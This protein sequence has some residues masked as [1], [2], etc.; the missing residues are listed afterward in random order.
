MRSLRFVL[1][2][3]G[4]G[5]RS[6]FLLSA[7]LVV[8]WG[9]VRGRYAAADPLTS[10]LSDLGLAAD[11]TL[12][13]STPRRTLRTFLDE[14]RAGRFDTAA[15]C[16]DLRG[17]PDARGGPELAEELSYILYRRPSLDLTRVPDDPTASSG[18]VTVDTFSAGDRDVPLSLSRVRFKDGVFRW[19]ISESTVTRIPEL[20][21]ALRSAVWR[22]VLPAVLQSPVILGNAPWQWLGVLVSL[23]VAYAVGRLFARMGR[24]IGLRLVKRSATPVDELMVK[25]SERPLRTI[26]A[27]LLFGLLVRSLD[28]SLELSKVL[29]HVGYSGFVIGL[30][31]LLLA[32]FGIVAQLASPDA[33]LVDR[34]DNPGRRT[35]RALLQR[36]ASAGVVGVTAAL[37]LLQFDVV[38]HVGLSLLASAGI[39]S[40]VL[41]FAGQKSISG[42]IAGIQLSITQ[43]VR[44]GDTIFIEGESGVVEDIFLTYAVIR[45]ID[46]RCLIVPLTRFLDQPFQNWTL[47]NRE[48]S[49]IVRLTVRFTAPIGKLR[50]KLREIC[51]ANSKWDKRRCELRV[52]DSDA[53]GMTLRMLVSASSPA[54]SSELAYDV[55]EAMVEFLRTLDD[56]KHLG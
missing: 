33:A 55:R 37:L 44:L 6:L 41:G 45:F 8:L 36:F 52:V 38:R 22:G 28:V 5:A 13:R 26:F 4:R 1:G 27:S 17:E 48:L 15:H 2:R 56:G 46:E 20:A 42:L 9:S 47:D 24:A 51:E 19:V 31:W 30:A 21:S 54:N 25:A 10:A 53:N 29:G 14:A 49:S 35:R 18:L 7:A 40:I 34:K 16:L 32:V 50:D 11:P 12:D 23:F 39:A 3:S 43:P